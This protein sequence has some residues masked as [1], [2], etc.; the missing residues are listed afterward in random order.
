MN[1]ETNKYNYIYLLLIDV[2]YLSL[3]QAQHTFE[4]CAQR[5]KFE[6]IVVNITICGILFLTYY[7]EFVIAVLAGRCT[8]PVPTSGE[9]VPQSPRDDP[10]SN[11]TPGKDF[12]YV[13]L[14][15]VGLYIKLFECNDV[16]REINRQLSKKRNFATQRSFHKLCQN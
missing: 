12:V 14:C 13:D 11:P 3:F 4:S 9:T 5:L 7:N 16:E 8:S 10:C 2:F 1:R 15:C 6:N